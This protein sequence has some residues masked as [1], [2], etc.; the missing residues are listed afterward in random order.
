MIDGARDTRILNNEISS[1]RYEGIMIQGPTT[2]VEISGNFIKN[3][4][5]TGIVARLASQK[6]PIYNNYFKN[7]KSSASENAILGLDWNIARSM[8]TNIVGGPYTGGNFWDDYT[9]ADLDGDG[10]GDTDIPYTANND[11]IKGDFAPLTFSTIG[12]FFDELPRV[13]KSLNF[14]LRD[15]NNSNTP[16]VL[17]LGITGTSTGIALGDGRKIPI[18][19]DAI[20]ELSLYNAATIGLTNSQ[21]WYNKNGIATST[22][23]I[24]DEPLL[25]NLTVYAALVTLD[26]AYN[27]LPKMIR[28]ISAPIEFKILP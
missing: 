8:G 4:G 12:I 25:K 17:L 27:S 9:G 15:P 11:L 22:W 28:S 24:L 19:Y 7:N 16:Y 21:D 3:N 10:I 1:N 23:N 14:H 5:R 2:N 20:T 18:N 6:V 26:P 13:G